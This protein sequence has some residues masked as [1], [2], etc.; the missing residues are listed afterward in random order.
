MNKTKKIIG[1]L[2]SISMLMFVATP[3][4]GS[5]QIILTENGA[6]SKNFTDVN[7]TSTSNTTQSNVATVTNNVNADAVSGGNN[8]SFNTGGQVS[9]LSGPATT[10]VD[11]TNLLNTNAAEVDC[12][13][14]NSASVEIS[15]NGYATYNQAYLDTINRVNVDQDNTANVTNNV[16]ANA[17]SGW[18][19]ALGNTGE[20]GVVTV[21]AGAAT[22]DVDVVTIANQNSA[23]VGPAQPGGSMVSAAII[24]N[25]ARSVNWI[26]LG[27][28]KSVV[29]DQD[30]IAR[31]T[32][33]VNAMAKSGKNSADYNTGA[34]VLVASGHAMAGADVLN[35]VNFNYADADCGCDTNVL[36]KIAG[37]GG[38][39]PYPDPM[40]GKDV[41]PIA[42]EQ[43]MVLPYWYFPASQNTIFA[44]LVS[45]NTV[46]QD[47]LATLNNNANAY[48]K[49]GWNRATANTGD[50]G[51]DPA[52]VSGA[53]SS[54]ATVTNDGNVN[55]S[56]S[57]PW[58]WPVEWPWT[59]TNVEVSMN[60][61]AMWAMWSAMWS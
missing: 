2:A 34:E 47:N 21:M 43:S 42:S 45:R 29:V 51:G 40:P 48:G 61:N 46:G 12:C 18:N 53:A 25:G 55:T 26:D 33:N 1:V 14:A 20:D 39:Y 4:L 60:F 22:T 27:V 52:V 11:V 31:I 38:G 58:T 16:D 54:H 57:M 37:N 35:S 3:I 50:H 49:S 19:R 30:N 10:D 15:N 44:D 23:H 32:N 8:A 13:G 5:T 6:G 36:A 24:G 7:Q 56:G 17:V 59:D 9:V 28:V 41:W